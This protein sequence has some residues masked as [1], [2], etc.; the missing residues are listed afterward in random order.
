[1]AFLNR[2][3]SGGD[4]PCHL[5]VDHTGHNVLVANYGGGSVAC[6]PLHPDGSLGAIRSFV[7]HHGSSVDKSRQQE[8]HAHYINVDAANKH[9][10]C[11][12][13]GMDQ[14]IIYR[15]D[16]AKGDLNSND[17]PSARVASGAG[18]RH[19]V[20]H[21]NGKFAYVINEMGSTV[22][23]FSFDPQSGGMKEIQ[24]LSTL[25]KGFTGST[26]TK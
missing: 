17:P 5:S 7:Q 4:G 8:P 19:M 23:A 2:E 15:F 24:T 22:T 20:F 12:D 6:L 9:A 11:A 21:P 16:A 3:S 18:P 10:F 14:V 13:L 25:P 26:T 1:M